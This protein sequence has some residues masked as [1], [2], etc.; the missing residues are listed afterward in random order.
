[1]FYQL[2]RHPLPV[3]AWFRHSLVLTYALPQSLLQPMLP[4]G[5]ELDTFQGLGF[6]AIA[7]VQTEGL[8]PEFLPTLFGQ[9]FFLA[10]YRIFARYRSSGGRTLRGL[11]ILRS[12]TN[13]RLMQ[14]A[15]NRLTHYQYRLAA[16]TWRETPDRLDIKVQ[17][18]RAE[19]DLDVTAFIADAAAPLPP[20]SP[21]ADLRQARL[22]AGPLPYT[23]DYEPQTHSIILIEG[24][25]DSWHPK[26]ITVEVRK[27]GFFGQS[28]FKGI[29]PVLANAFL[30]SGIPYR[31]KR[32]VRDPLPK[33]QMAQPCEAR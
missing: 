18:P 26:P 28:S 3:R 8:R 27:A 10:G 22:F 7:L 11:R 32:G 2:Q 4:P 33:G 19:A 23:F 30:V 31:W 1:M 21:F 5:L 6:V 15:G 14:V 13:R 16:V 29:T 9:N 20:G 17:T 12:D 25:R 24:E